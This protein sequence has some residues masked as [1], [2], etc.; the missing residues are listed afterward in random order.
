MPPR[1]RPGL[2]RA[3]LLLLA[4]AAR[5]AWPERPVQI[6]APFAAGG[7][8]DL[9]ARI[10]ARFLERQAGQPFIVLNRP[11]AGGEIGWAAVAE[12]PPDGHTLALLNI[13]S[14]LAI[15]IERQ[16]RFRPGDFAL[17]ANIVDDPGTFAVRT[18]SPIRSLEDLLTAMRARP[19]EVSY[20]T[21]GVGAAGHIAMLLFGL[22]SG[23]SALH[24]PF[25]GTAGVA[26]ALL[27]GQIE[28]ATAT[29]SE[30]SSFAAGGAAGWRVLG[31]MAP[32]RL[33]LR[34]E[35]A[36]FAEQGWP[37]EGG[38]LRG[39][40]APR[41]T[42]PAVLAAIGAAVARMNADPDYRAAMAQARLPIRYL[43]GAD[44]AALLQ[45]MQTS[46]EELWRANPWNR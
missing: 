7:G 8:V 35:I 22:R 33:E 39:L 16:A 24:V 42:P 12:A 23:T 27:G 25:T 45:R 28:L 14:L 15:P 10:A 18:D 30:V 34:P 3:L 26:A 4:P 29:L 5:A 38:S 9:T 2:L 44:Y 31:V 37:V 1:A 19:G 46:L 21:A 43:P 20:G 6:V 17:I 40:G 41:A 11:G 32:Q 36:T 13:P